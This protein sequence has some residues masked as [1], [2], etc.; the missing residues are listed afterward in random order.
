[1]A[2]DLVTELLQYSSLACFMPIWQ[3]CANMLIPNCL[4]SNLS[5]SPLAALELYVKY[6]KSM[7]LAFNQY[8]TPYNNI[9]NALIVKAL[10]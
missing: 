9:H 3:L 7:L 8:P 10:L 4:R 5:Y 1:M 2:H 6:G